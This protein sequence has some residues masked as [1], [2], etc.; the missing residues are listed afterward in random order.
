[1]YL[2]CTFPVPSLHLPCTFP[3][4]SLLRHL[5]VQLAKVPGGNGW[6]A[7]SL[8]YTPDS[9]TDVV[10]TKQALTS[11]RQAFTFLWRLKRVEH[12]L[13][14]VWRKHGTAARLLRT[15]RSDGT[16][17]RCH[18][19]RNEMI[20][21][22]YNM[23]YYLMH[24]VI[25]CSWSELLAGLDAAHDL[26]GLIAAHSSFLSAIATKAL[27]GPENEPMRLS[28]KALFEA[29]L[30]FAKAQDVLYMS[31]LEQKAASRQ[32]AAAVA[33]SAEAG[34]W[35]PAAEPPPVSVP[36]RFAQQL[37]ASALEYEQRFAT[38]FAQVTQHAALDLRFLSFRLDFNEYYESLAAAR[39][40][41][42]EAAA[43]EP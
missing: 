22:V 30:G 42:E 16:L 18:L 5:D 13:T 34:E 43:L 29:I 37:A 27:L 35:G 40:A 10:F 6:D 7:F 2:P 21:F 8:D 31:L 26:D 9:P 38:F 3:V 41:D 17:H 33:A 19:L 25:E 24:E 1:M 14:A 11:Y 36:P 28:L 15:L 20:H 12:S 23:Q 39:A 32:H 4:P